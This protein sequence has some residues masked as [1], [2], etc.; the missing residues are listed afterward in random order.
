MRYICQTNLGILVT[1]NYN[2]IPFLKFGDQKPSLYLHSPNNKTPA[3]IDN[4][5]KTVCFYKEGYLHRDNG[6]ALIYN[7]KEYIFYYNGLC[8]IDTYLLRINK[9]ILFNIK[10]H[11]FYNKKD[12]I[13]TNIINQI[14]S[15]ISKN[16][17]IKLLGEKQ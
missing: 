3:F 16:I 7:N 6:P 15:F 12:K 13:V 4:F 8:D 2:E 17:L 14:N 9:N 1:D 5:N 11:L 10:M